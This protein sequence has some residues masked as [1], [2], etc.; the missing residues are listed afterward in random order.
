M[1]RG[2]FIVILFFKAFLVMTIGVL[3]SYRR[4][5]LGKSL[6]LC[7]L[8]LGSRLCQVILDEI[9]LMPDIQYVCLHVHTEND[10]ALRFYTKRGFAIDSRVDGYYSRNLGV[11]GQPD[12]Y[13]LVR[14]NTN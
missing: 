12:A 6:T 8:W 3:A 2:E 14:S 1:I 11:R 10:Q 9:D 13:F 5:G 4:L 7:L